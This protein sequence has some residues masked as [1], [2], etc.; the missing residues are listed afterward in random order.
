MVRSWVRATSDESPTDTV[1]PSRTD[2]LDNETEIFGPEPRRRSDSPRPAGTDGTMVKAAALA[3]PI[4][5]P[6]ELG[7]SVRVTV[8]S[9][10]AAAEA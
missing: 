4:V 6:A 1:L 5:Y 7:L 8:S 10:S 9:V 3:R 2:S